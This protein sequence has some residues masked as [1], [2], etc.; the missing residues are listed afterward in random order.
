[1]AER[2]SALPY[3]EAVAALRDRRLP[4]VLVDLD[5]LERNVDRV[6]EMIRG[7]GTPLRMATK[8]VRVVELIRRIVARG[9]DD[10]RGLMCF[11][12]EE[13]AFLARE[14]FDDLLVAYPTFQRHDVE[15]AARLTGEGVR[16]R[17]MTDS[18]E[19]V[20]RFGEV[21]TAAGVTL[22]V[23][24]CVDMSLELASQ[25]LGVYRSPLHDPRD[26]VALAQKVDATA[27]TRFGGIM[28]YEAQVAG[29]GDDSPFEPLLNPAKALVRR[30]SIFELGRRRVAMVKALRE[31]GLPPEL[32]NGGGTGSL[33]S[34]TPE[35][36]VTELTAGSAFLKP[37]LFD[38]Y[39]DPHMQAL[40]P[41]FYFALEVTRKPR[42]DMA[43]C[44]GGGYVAS[45]AVSPDKVPRVVMPEGLS[46]VEAEMCGEVQ[47]PLQGAEALHI[48]D[49]VL[50]RHAKGGEL[51]ERFRHYLL[52]RGSDVEAE[53]PTYRGQ[54]QCF[55]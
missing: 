38:Y 23:I 36:G 55:F 42:P 20:A 47:T 11:A 39:R 24:L 54:N 53:V 12:T 29:L 1:M 18:A 43:T 5:A 32:V 51:A 49:P 33:H 48:G 52:V 21:A 17:I 50:F 40:E 4:A 37:H 35:T 3:D 26:V 8:S 34:T 19:G 7:R 30:V 16:L 25:H 41:A 15:L 45:G 13:A 2:V 22:E 44:L 46:L 28:G 27:G 6:A 14:G 9:G 31:A 10:F